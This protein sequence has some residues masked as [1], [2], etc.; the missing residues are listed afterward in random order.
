M[1][2]VIGYFKFKAILLASDYCM[3]QKSRPFVNG[4]YTIMM[5]QF[6]SL[7]F[8]IGNKYYV[9]FNEIQWKNESF[10]L[11]IVR[12]QIFQKSQSGSGPDPTSKKNHRPDP[13]PTFRKIP[14][15]RYK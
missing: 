6:T 3:S 14:N 15:S 5:E 13:E 9:K 7:K 10:V 1:Y 2:I 8:W 11:C 12:I 4:E